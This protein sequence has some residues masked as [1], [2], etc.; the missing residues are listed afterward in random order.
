MKKTVLVAMSGGVDS[1]VTAAI[2]KDQGYNLFGVTMQIWPGDEP[3][4]RGSG[5]CCSLSAV[6]DARR[7]AET[8]DIPFYVMN[9]RSLFQKEVID[10]F[11][12]EYL[13]GRT[14]NPCIVCN[15]KVKFAALLDKA[16][17]M[18][19]D[20]IATG[21]YARVAYDQSYQRFVMKKALDFN[22]DQTYVLYG[23][24]QEQLSHTLLPLGD[25]T[26]PQI[27]EMARELG[28]SVAEKPESQEICF[29]TDNNYRR[30]IK[31]KAGAEIKPGPML[32]TRGEII[33]THQGI[34]Y[35]T[36]GQ[37]K[38]LG[39]ALGEPAYV[40][41]IDTEKNAIIIGS[42]EELRG[43]S[44]TASQNNFIIFDHLTEPMDVTVKI[45]YK[46]KEVPATI[47]PLADG[48]VRVDFRE[49]ERAITPGQ[50]VVYYLNDY[51]VGGG[52]IQ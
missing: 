19:A 32:N 9:F 18:G 43:I 16:R 2:L 33:G 51:V 52:I 3:D 31:E 49:A 46:A 13:E 38:G 35:Y 36:I 25:Y 22:K 21:H 50:A 29:V 41:D 45:R 8:L 40:V 39:L 10:Y 28:L 20:Y 17:A 34:P 24:T 14:P 27:R 5:G 44:L 1:S 15:Q 6:E 37:R 7:V 12:D 23:F 26:K 30:F 47:V 11:V 4:P 48:R 42:R